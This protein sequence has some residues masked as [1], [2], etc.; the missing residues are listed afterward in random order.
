M[1]FGCDKITGD[2]FFYFPAHFHDFARELV[3]KDARRLHTVLRPRI[4]LIDMQICATNR[5]RFYFNKYI[6]RAYLRNINQSNRCSRRRLGFEG[7]LHFS[8]HANR[9]VDTYLPAF[10]Q[11]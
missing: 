6:T 8:V 7:R 1:R 3:T 10:R 11:Q 4:P 2:K 5:S 9:D